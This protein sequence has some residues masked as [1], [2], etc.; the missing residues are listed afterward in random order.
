MKRIITIA[1]ILFI[2]INQIFAQV[3]QAINFQAIARNSSGD[4]L[5]NTDIKIRLTII[6]GSFMD[7][8]VYQEVRSLTTNGFGAFSFQIG[9][10]ADYVS[11]GEFSEIEW[12]TGEKFL[13]IDYNPSNQ[14]DWSLSL[15]TIELVTVPYSFSAGSVTSIDMSNVSDGDILVYNS[16]T[17]KYES[18][19]LSD[20]SS[21]WSKT[22][23]HI[24]YNTGNIGIGTENPGSDLE[25]VGDGTDDDIIR[26]KNN[27]YSRYASYTY[28]S[29]QMAIPAFVGFRSRGTIETPEN[30]IADDRITGL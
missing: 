27:D 25:I 8:E 24:Y 9:R 10:D 19:H 20:Y 13:K 29:E 2:S 17:E 3:P 22:G 26:I 15:G 1:A 5:S 7:N 6:D 11:I 21:K 4:V 16:L 23:N 18:K 28:S 30:V 14:E 12:E